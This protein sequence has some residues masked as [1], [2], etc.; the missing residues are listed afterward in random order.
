MRYPIWTSACL[1]ALGAFSVALADPL[2]DEVTCAEIGFS[3]AA[4][5]RDLNAFKS[6]ID[7][8]ARFVGATVM[9]GPEAVAASW[10]PFFEDGGPL[11]S[12]RPLIVQ[13]SKEGN[14]ALSRGAYQVSSVGADGTAK[15]VWGTFN[16]VWRKDESGRW[17]VLFDM[18]GDHGKNPSDAE[19][20]L[21]D[22]TYA[23]GTN[24]TG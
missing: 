5:H 13:V 7:A 12:W 17:K 19:L 18:G 11:I 16:S 15:T 9:V 4:E 1:I 23:C 20:A 8:D 6:F 24:H 21:F 3:N 14:L 2:V 22:Q 10:E